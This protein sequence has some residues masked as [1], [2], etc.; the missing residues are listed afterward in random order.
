MGDEKM[1][2]VDKELCPQ[3]H[4]CPA[5]RVCP[6][7]AI[8]QEGNGLPVIDHDKCI[9]CGQCIDFCPKGALKENKVFSEHKDHKIFKVA[10]E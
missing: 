3:N 7:G 2:F 10:S 4:R 1:I 5:I 6:E 8:S 9:S